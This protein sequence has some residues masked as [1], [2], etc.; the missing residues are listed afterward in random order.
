MML[1]VLLLTIL[2]IAVVA[3]EVYDRKLTPEQ[4]EARREDNEKGIL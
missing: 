2:A 4:R 3:I 1:F